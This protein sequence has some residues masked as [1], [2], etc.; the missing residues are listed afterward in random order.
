MEYK[1]IVYITI[2]Q[3]NG[4]F[5]IGVHKTINPDIFDNYIGCGVTSQST[6]K[7]IQ[8]REKYRNPFVNAVVKYGYENFKRTTIKT[9]DIEQD[10]YNLEAIL[11][12]ETLLK[13]KSC[14]NIAL[15][16]K[17]SFNC[18]ERKIYQFDL[19]GNYLRSFKS[20][21]LAADAVGVDQANIV[22]CL[23]GRQRKSGG[24]Y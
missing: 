20:I 4:K 10:A 7:Y 5:Y 14:Y 21:Q 18:I 23:N 13:S 1:Y 12:N 6:A 2:N 11:V 9:F 3:C 8:K 15:G 22:A 16:G 17:I 24:Y 19:N